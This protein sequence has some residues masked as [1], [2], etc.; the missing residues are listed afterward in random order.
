[1]LVYH[2]ANSV[3][4]FLS[5]TP[6]ASYSRTMARA[7]HGG[8]IFQRPGSENWW[9]KLRS[10]TG[11]VEKSLHTV[12][13]REAE[14]LA[15]P[16]IAEHKAAL[17]AARPRL[18]E[19]W[20]FK[21]EP[22]LHVSPDGGHIA[23]TERELT[24]YDSAG[25]LV[26]TEPNG[27][28]AFQLVGAASLTLRSLAEAF[29]KADFG[30]GSGERGRSGIE[31]RRWLREHPGRWWYIKDLQQEAAPPGP[32]V[33]SEIDLGPVPAV[34]NAQ[35]SSR[36]VRDNGGDED[37]VALVETRAGDPSPSHEPTSLPTTATATVKNGTPKAKLL[38]GTKAT[39]SEAEGPK[40]ETTPLAATGRKRGR[41]RGH[42]LSPERMRIVLD[43][44]RERPI[45]SDA[46]AKAGI[47]RKTLE[48]WLKR[49]EAGD[50]GYDLEWR[51]ETARFH[52]HYESAIGEGYDELVLRVVDIAMGG[53][54]YKTEQ[55][56]VDRGLRGPDAYLRDANGIP[57]VET[58][59][60]PNGKMLR[61]LLELLRPK[62]WGKHRKIDVPQTGGV[63]VVGG[64]PH[65]IPNKVNNGTAA[66]VKARKWKV[67]WRM[68]QETEV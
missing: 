20:R 66:S 48:Y 11:R 3:A 14:I 22:G 17:L 34:P 12:V 32:P 42:Q 7:K 47:H 26:R 62:K 55:S 2:V 18:L 6:V 65:D 59:R 10:P 33:E 24:H 27:V 23:A 4:N 25:G 15:L 36:G 21:L 13:R 41:R 60:N 52:E 35:T 68:L 61:F 9:I 67:G 5:P 40:T 56:L 51:G 38:R 64:I 39:A 28:P 8:Y 54:I 49:S 30:D 44:L 1:M 19:T 45:L 46:A 53:V 63:L 31:Q 37:D 29:I 50:D 43:S 57:V 16:L 58:I